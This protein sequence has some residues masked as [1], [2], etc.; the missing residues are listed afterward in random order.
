MSFKIS[1]TAMAAFYRSMAA[2]HLDAYRI[3]YTSLFQ[4]SNRKS[5]KTTDFPFRISR[6]EES[7]RFW[8]EGSGFIWKIY[9]PAFSRG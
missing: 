9:R 5:W 2:P 8:P 7:L 4:K 6:K 1:D 3:H